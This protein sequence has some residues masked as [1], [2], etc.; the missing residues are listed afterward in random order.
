MQWKSR[1]EALVKLEA[2]CK[3]QGQLGLKAFADALL[4]I[5][6]VLAQNPGLFFKET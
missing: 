1:C 4:I 2:Q 6:K 5:P 3:G